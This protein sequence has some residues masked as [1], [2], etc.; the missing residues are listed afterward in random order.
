MSEEPLYRYSNLTITDSKVNIGR[1]AI[2]H[3][4][5]T[6]TKMY[7]DRRPFTTAPLILLVIGCV[8]LALAVRDFSL[9]HHGWLMILFALFFISINVFLLMY[10]VDQLFLFVSGR[11][12]IC[13]LRVRDR[14]G[15]E[16]TRTALEAAIGPTKTNQRKAPTR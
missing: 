16:R 11:A 5:I 6:G 12:P 3:A 15:I 4:D 1:M 2:S 9:P 10:R 8:F 14:V 7:L 13:A